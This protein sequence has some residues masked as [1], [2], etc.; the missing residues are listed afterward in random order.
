MESVRG[1]GYRVAYQ[2][3]DFYEPDVRKKVNWSAVIKDEYQ[4][5]ERTFDEIFQRSSDANNISFATGLPPAVYDEAN[6]AA[7]FAAIL[8]IIRSASSPARHRK[9]IALPELLPVNIHP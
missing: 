6:L 1:V 5:M 3:K 2:S 7:D 8:K 9:R 4:D